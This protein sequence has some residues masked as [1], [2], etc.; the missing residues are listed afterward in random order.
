MAEKDIALICLSTFEDIT[1]YVFQKIKDDLKNIPVKHASYEY[2]KSLQKINLN[3]T[4]TATCSIATN[5]NDEDA[6][7][8]WTKTAK[9][10]H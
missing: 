5:N 2:K 3:G 8:G 7:K 6:F 10:R 9:K 4:Q 1:S